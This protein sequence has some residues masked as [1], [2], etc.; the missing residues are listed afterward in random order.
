MFIIWSGNGILVIVAALLGAWGAHH[1]TEILHVSEHY[2]IVV[3]AW[4]IALTTLLYAKTIGRTTYQE[5]IDPHTR[6]KVAQVRRHSLFFFPV[7]GW[8][9]LCLLIAGALT[10]LAIFTAF[11]PDE[12]ASLAETEQTDS[13]AGTE[14]EASSP[15]VS[16]APAASTLP[17]ELRT[18]TSSDGRTIEARLLR[19]LPDRISGEFVRSDGQAFTIEKAR[20]SAD[21]QA[22][23]DQ[24]AD[25]AP[26]P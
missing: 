6:Q 10:G 2:K 1:L 8:A 17:T 13:A 12:P 7:F 5:W 11:A 25:Q 16:S 15:P 22:F 18:W 19:I 4:G 26:P 9:V 14:P 21:D 3:V 20:L 23:F 24:L